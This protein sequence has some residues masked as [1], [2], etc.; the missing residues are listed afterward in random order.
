MNKSFESMT[1]EEQRKQ[2]LKSQHESFKRIIKDEPFIDRIQY[3]MLYVWVRVK[4]TYKQRPLLQLGIELLIALVILYFLNNA[5][6][7]F[8][9]VK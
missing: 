8:F 3:R 1:P 2:I 9:M 6:D 4:K 5:I 7:F